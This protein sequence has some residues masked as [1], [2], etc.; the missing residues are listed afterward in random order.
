MNL[1]AVYPLNVSG[2]EGYLLCN[3]G[4]YYLNTFNVTWYGTFS[5]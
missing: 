1:L 4:Y 3:F 5:R 2:I